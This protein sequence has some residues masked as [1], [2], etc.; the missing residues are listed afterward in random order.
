LCEGGLCGR[1]CVTHTGHTHTHTHK[2][3]HAFTHIYAHTFAHTH[4]TCMHVYSHKRERGDCGGLRG[5]AYGDV[6]VFVFEFVFP[7]IGETKNSIGFYSEPRFPQC[8][9]LFQSLMKFS[10]VQQV[11]YA[12]GHTTETAVHP[13]SH[14]VHQNPNTRVFV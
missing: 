2:H 12:G 5:H 6:S 11:P 9:S 1:E 3:T 13:N 7:R 10:I 14:G 4:K 8:L